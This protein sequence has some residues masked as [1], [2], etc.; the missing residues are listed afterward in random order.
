MKWYTTNK[1]NLVNNPAWQTILDYAKTN[2]FGIDTIEERLP[3]LPTQY[4]KY[5]NVSVNPVKTAIT[6]LQSVFPIKVD[7][8]NS[9]IEL[10]DGYERFTISSLR[11]KSLN[12][13]I[14]VNNTSNPL[15]GKV[16]GNKIY[17]N[18]K[19]DPRLNYDDVFGTCE[20][21]VTALEYYTCCGFP[22]TPNAYWTKPVLIVDISQ[23]FD[24]KTYDGS[25]P[26]LVTQANSVRRVDDN[27]TGMPSLWAY[28]DEFVFN[29]SNSSTI[30]E[31]STNV[32]KINEENV[33]LREKLSAISKIINT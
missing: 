15:G 16:D 31:P 6:T 4:D 5:L 2:N 17:L 27:F 33:V 18:T 11:S 24:K 29:N 1:T 14:Y 30:N 28:V 21:E 19:L 3:Y 22:A 20:G 9:V 13:T 12:K 10:G 23:I 8:I 25:F 7:A 26:L 32:D